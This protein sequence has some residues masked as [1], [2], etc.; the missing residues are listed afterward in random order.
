MVACSI[1]GGK[2]ALRMWHWMV[3]AVVQGLTEFL[4]VSS[5]A[6]LAVIPQLARWQ[7]PG[8]AFDVSLHLGTLF[9]VLIYFAPTWAQLLRSFFIP[10]TGSALMDSGNTNAIA[11]SSSPK[12]GWWIVLGTAPAVATGILFHR[13]AETTLRSLPV[14]G[15]MLILVGLLIWLAER[16][17]SRS[18]PLSSLT[19]LDALVIGVA[20]AFAVIPGVSRSGSTIAAGLAR[21]LE[22]DSAASFSFL[23]SA[24]VMAGA[25]LFEGHTLLKVG[26]PKE[27]QLPLVLAILLSGVTGY[28]SMWGMIRYVRVRSMMVFVLYRIIAGVTILLIWSFGLV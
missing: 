27:M 26:V 22:R 28:L 9:S 10:V 16:L 3:L 17:G 24:P 5:T 7:D 21:G 25:A 14:M 6:H 23:L 18:K 20:Q 8:L 2:T 15:S 4:P 11:A 13:N 1:F 12:L 19:V